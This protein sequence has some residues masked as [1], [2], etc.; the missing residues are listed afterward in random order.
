MNKKQNKVYYKVPKVRGQLIAKYFEKTTV[1][2]LI[3]ANS[4]W[5]HSQKLNSLPG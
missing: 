3:L 1:S 4:V 5:R 2:R